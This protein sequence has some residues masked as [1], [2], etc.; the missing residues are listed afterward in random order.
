MK[1]MDYYFWINSD[2]AY[3]GINRMMEIARRHDVS[4]NYKPVD[5][6]QVYAR[7]GGIPLPQRSPQR[8]AYREQELRRWTARL[9]IAVNITPRYMCPD[10]ALAS[11]FVIAAQSL[12]EP[13]AALHQKILAAEWCDERDISD[14]QVLL[15]VAHGLAMPAEQILRSAKEQAAADTLQHYTDQAVACGVFGSPSYVYD[16]ELFW[17]QDRLEF[18]EERIIRST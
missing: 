3:L 6:L 13:V 8:R 7:T 1:V 17:G 10:G 16:G 18:L 14:E 2:W 15:D 5:L 12:G 9:D 11:R 4:I